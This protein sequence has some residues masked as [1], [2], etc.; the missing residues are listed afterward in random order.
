ML[1][2]RLRPAYR[3]LRPVVEAGFDSSPW[4]LK[5]ESISLWLDDERPPPPGW[6]GV[7]TFSAALVVL[8]GCR[9]LDQSFPATIIRG[10]QPPYHL[11]RISLDH[12]LGRNDWNSRLGKPNTGHDLALQIEQ[13]AASGC[14]PPCIW[15]CHSTNPRGRAKIRAALQNADRYWVKRFPEWEPESISC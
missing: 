9:R 8:K 1:I 7:K 13:W 3:P 4:Q 11:D 15:G 5:Q 12:D 2:Q 14:L 6:V 10:D